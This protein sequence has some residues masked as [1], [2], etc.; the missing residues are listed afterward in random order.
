MRAA[1]YRASH[2][3]R[4]RRPA[5]KSDPLAPA[6][7]AQGPGEITVS[8]AFATGLLQPGRSPLAS[9]AQFDLGPVPTNGST[10]PKPLTAQRLFWPPAPGDHD[11]LRIGALVVESS[12]GAVEAISDTRLGATLSA[13]AE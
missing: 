10:V 9:S 1:D 13:A 4:S 6:S 8:V 11:I 2:E 5:S 3:P 7:T 12:T